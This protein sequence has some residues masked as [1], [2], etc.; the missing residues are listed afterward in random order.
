M[1]KFVIFSLYDVT[2]AAHNAYC[3][4]QL[5]IS[6]P[7]SFYLYYTQY[8]FIVVKLFLYVYIN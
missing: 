7:A 6:L 5:H 3:A 2:N 1:P 4:W 8:A